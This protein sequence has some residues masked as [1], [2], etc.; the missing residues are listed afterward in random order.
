MPASGLTL[1]RTA[2][3]RGIVVADVGIADAPPARLGAAGHWRAQRCDHDRRRGSER[4]TKRRRWVAGWAHSR[5]RWR[6]IGRLGQA[7][8]RMRDLWLARTARVARALRSVTR[9]ARNDRI[10]RAARQRRAFCCALALRL[11]A[12]F[13]ALFAHFRAE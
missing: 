11:R 6:R 13:P 9:A 7:D 10:R 5:A 1:A 2:V 3:V 12:G 4:R 8:A